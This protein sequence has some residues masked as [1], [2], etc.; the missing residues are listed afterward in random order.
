MDWKSQLSKSD[1]KALEL[2]REID[3]LEA[4]NA[5]LREL[6]EFFVDADEIEAALAGGNDE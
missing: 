5:K 1:L 2:S 4:E 3:R 6:L